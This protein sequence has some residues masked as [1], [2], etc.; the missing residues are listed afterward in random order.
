MQD[1]KNLILFI[2]LSVGILFGWGILFPPP[3]P[4]KP[5]PKKRNL[6]R[7]QPNQRR[8]TPAQTRKGTKANPSS[9]PTSAPASGPTSKATTMAARQPTLRPAPPQRREP[10]IPTKTMTF[11]NKLYTVK[12]SNQGGGVVSM[13]LKKF[14]QG[15]KGNKKPF[16]L[17]D[18]LLKSHPPIIERL[19]DPQLKS[20][21]SQSKGYIVYNKISQPKPEVILLQ[22]Q[23]K[24]PRGGLV[25][26]EKRYIFRKKSYQFDVEYSLT[27]RTGQAIK[28]SMALK[29]TDHEDPK[30]L[31]AG[32]MFSQPELLQVL[33]H[34][35]KEQSPQ[36]FDSTELAKSTNQTTQSFSNEKL[37][38]ELFRANSSFAA[39]DRRYFLFSILPNWGKG[40]QTVTCEA[41]GNNG[42]WV[43]AELTNAGVNIAPNTTHKFKVGA[44][45]GPKYYGNLQKVGKD[46]QQ[47]I[48]FG[49]FA[50]LSRPMLWLM[51][52][53]YNS[54]GN[55]G[56]WGL[57]II[58]L[59][60]LVK[61]IT[62]P[63]THRSMESMKKMQK[64]K[65]EM[66]RLKEKY[67]DDK[68]SF[69]R[70]MMNV[71]VKEGINP[72]SGCL[73]MLVQMPVW[74]A[75]YNTLFYAVELYQAPFIR[76]WIDDLSSKDPFYILPVSMGI[77]MFFQQ[78]LTPQTMDNAQAKAMLWFMPIFF[79]FIMLFLPAGLTLYIFVNTILGLLHHWY[80]HTRPD[81]PE[82]K[83][84]KKK[85]KAGWMERM[86]KLV[87]E[88][89]QKQP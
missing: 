38:I 34:D 7:N 67:G 10:V 50:F 39:L 17:I 6:K 83:K 69:Q 31:T 71:Y 15:K 74:F 76:G 19:L 29:L 86:Q 41:R 2:V 13:Q 77:A 46:L 21:T 87:D 11:S 23:V 82:D 78:R 40:D 20:S 53:F 32:G 65:P 8:A 51:Q 62:W 25:Q 16:N 57:A 84:P 30:K 27:N 22:G 73:P 26:V 54:M 63:L 68:E 42:G 36:R 3:K 45:F 56:N 58:L 61:L 64:L 9:R 4:I 43:Q 59:T 37:G 79:T 72:I 33:C 35:P 55:W 52:F 5:P 12:V 14:T 47:S 48:N 85:K 18:G 88:Q 44:Y 80:I 1:S 49:F 60:L 24:S 75:L 70:E 66:D 28:S 89:Q 81:K